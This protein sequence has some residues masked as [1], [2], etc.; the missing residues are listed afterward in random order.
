MFRRIS[1]EKEIPSWESQAG[2]VSQSCSLIYTYIYIYICIYSIEH[3][4]HVY[5]YVYTYIHTYI[6]TYI[7]IYIYIHIYIYTHIVHLVYCIIAYHIVLIPAVLHDALVAERGHERHELL[8]RE[9][10]K[11][12]LVKGGF[13]IY[14][15]FVYYYYHYYYHVIAKPPFTKPP[16]VNSRLLRPREHHLLQQDDVGLRQAQVL[17]DVYYY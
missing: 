8:L 6:H 3:N 4:T 11:G 16:F 1:S 14:A 12:S 2:N 10:T 17:R 13:V 7:Y 9:Y 15:S 5:I